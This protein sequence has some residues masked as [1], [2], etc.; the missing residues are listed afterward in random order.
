MR[1]GRV[2]YDTKTSMQMDRERGKDTEIDIFTKDI[3]KS[4]KELA[5]PRPLHNEIYSQLKMG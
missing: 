5:I 2:A 1:I 3:I 4:A